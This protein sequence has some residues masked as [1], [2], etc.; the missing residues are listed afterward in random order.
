MINSNNRLLGTLRMA[1]ALALIL[2]AVSSAQNPP[3]GDVARKEQARRKAAKSSERVLTNKDLP[4]SSARPAPSP[5]P[6]PEGAAGAAVTEQKEAAAADPAEQKKDEE[7]EEA[8]WRQRITQARDGLRRSEVFLEALQT[9][10]NV[11]STDF[12]NRDDPVQRARIGEDRQ[13]AIAEMERVQ[14]E[15]VQYRKQI[16]DI[17]EEARKA[18]I[19]PGW[20]R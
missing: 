11:L 14:A 8:W 2:P 15:I 18:G 3:L 5:G 4:P 19:P 16:A 6:A 9:R 12:V 13:K 20:L 1:A 17:E 10:V 7:K